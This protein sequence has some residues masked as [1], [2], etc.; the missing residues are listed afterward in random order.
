[1]L[2]INDLLFQLHVTDQAITQLFEKRLGISLTR[3]ELLQFLLASAPC[4]QIRLQ[5]VLKI[6]QAALTRHFKVLEENGYVTRTRNPQNQRE[7]LVDVTEFAKKQ[8]VTSPPRHHLAAKAQMEQILTDEEMHTLQT[9]LV[10]LV[11][12]LETITIDKD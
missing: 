7:I 10:K 12:G 8:L 4:S 11:T 3:Y 1:M 2:A 6:N 5:E 9:L